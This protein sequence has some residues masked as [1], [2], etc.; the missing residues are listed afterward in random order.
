[1]LNESKAEAAQWVIWLQQLAYFDTHSA[2]VNKQVPTAGPRLQFLRFTLLLPFG[3]SIGT[4]SLA[5]SKLL[6]TLQPNVSLRQSI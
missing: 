3:C 6:D 1:M 4:A 2:P 5:T